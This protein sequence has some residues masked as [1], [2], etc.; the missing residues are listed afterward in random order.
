MSIAFASSN[1]TTSLPSGAFRT[2]FQVSEGTFR[3][4]FQVYTFL[5]IKRCVRNTFLHKQPS[6]AAIPLREGFLL[7]CQLRYVTNGGFMT[8]YDT[9]RSLERDLFH[10]SYGR[11]VLVHDFY[12]TLS[13]TKQKSL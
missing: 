2:F 5:H 9:V 11:D 3:T 8:V 7:N 1:M 12:C 13:K 10:S 6:R 4:F